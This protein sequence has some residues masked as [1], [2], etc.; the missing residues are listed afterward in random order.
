VNLQLRPVSYGLF[1]IALFAARVCAQSTGTIS[2]FVTDQSGALVP[3]ARV[4]ATLV[5]QNVSRSV[6]SNTN[7]FYIFNALP[8]GSYT[9]TAEITG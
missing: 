8:P 9:I 5:E 7:G 4:T 2:G 6:E 1:L 3:N